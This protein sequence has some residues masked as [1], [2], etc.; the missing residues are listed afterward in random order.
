MKTITAF[1]I[2]T[3]GGNLNTWMTAINFDKLPDFNYMGE[4]AQK[5][6]EGSDHEVVECFAI[7]DDTKNV[8][9]SKGVLDKRDY[10]LMGDML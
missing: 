10:E 2:I 4:F 1:K 6:N 7:M 5:V 8:I 9:Y 3:K